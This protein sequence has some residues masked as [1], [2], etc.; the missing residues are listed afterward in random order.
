MFSSV[1][2]SE[3]VRNALNLGVHTCTIPWKV[4]KQLPVNH[5]TD[6]GTQQN[7]EEGPMPSSA[8][9]NPNPGFHSDE[10]TTDEFVETIEDEVKSDSLKNIP[11]KV[12]PGNIH[13]TGDTN[14]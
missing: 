10:S 8:I 2:H 7:I 13:L 1:R 12:K 5:F 4:M 9:G 3:H 14:K 11:E 6:I